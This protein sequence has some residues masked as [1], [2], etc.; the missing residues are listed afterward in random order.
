MSRSF[1]WQPTKRIP[2]GMWSSGI[3]ATWSNHLSLA[4]AN[5]LLIDSCMPKR[6]TS[7]VVVMC[8]THC[9]VQPI[10]MIPLTQWRWKVSSFLTSF[11]VGVQVSALYKRTPSTTDWQ[12]SLL[13]SNPRSQAEHRIVQLTKSSRS[14]CNPVTYIL[15]HPIM[16]LYQWHQILKFLHYLYATTT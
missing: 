13:V 12:T 16:S 4:K 10:P 7:W 6:S 15:C 2:F 9:I 8:S 11:W 14:L 1:L 5:R 3:R